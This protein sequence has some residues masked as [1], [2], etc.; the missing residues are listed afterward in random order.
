MWNKEMLE[1]WEKGFVATFQESLRSLSHSLGELQCLSNPAG[2]LRTV[3]SQ[4]WTAEPR[5]CSGQMASLQRT[6]SSLQM[7]NK[8]QY[9]AGL[10]PGLLSQQRLGSTRGEHLQNADQKPRQQP[11][12]Y[13]LD[14][15]TMCSV[16]LT[17]CSLKGPSSYP[18]QTG[19]MLLVT[20]GKV[21]KA[22]LLTWS[23]FIDRAIVKG[24]NEN[25]YTN[26]KL[27]IGS[28]SNYQVFQ[29]V[30]DHAT[31]A[32]LPYQ[33]PWMPDVVVR[34]SV[35]WLRS[36]IKLFQAPCQRCRKFLQ[37]GL[38]PVWRDFQTLEVFC[39]TCRQ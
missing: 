6:S 5:S 8:L 4:Q 26:G 22:T 13:L 31:T 9:R 12:S 19:P 25:V 27:D 10:A 38:L 14:M 36:Y 16:A 21:L 34:S 24:Y 39:D 2:E 35:T 29:K 37:D 17:E 32:L 1:G 15:L 7:V 11:S 33:L 23:L 28:Q 30:M 18:C 3:P 20:L